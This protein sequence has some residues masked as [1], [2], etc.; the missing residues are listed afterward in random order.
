MQKSRR[1]TFGKLSAGSGATKAKA[2]ALKGR[3]YKVR[4]TAKG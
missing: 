1:D 3:R 4:R 2:S